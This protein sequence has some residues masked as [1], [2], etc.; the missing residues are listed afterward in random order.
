MPDSIVG[1]NFDYT[2]NGILSRD[3]MF[4]PTVNTP[5]IGD[6]MTIRQFA[7]YQER[8]PLVA[9]LT[10]Q[11]KAYANCGRSFTDGID[12]TNA[13]LSLTPLELNMEWC[14]DDFEQTLLIGNNLAEDFLRDGIEEFNP[15]GTQIQSIIDELVND[16]MR[17]DT[18]RIFSFGDTN[19]AD[20]DWNQLDGLWT[21]LIANSGVGSSYCVRRTGHMGTGTLA[22][23]Q[24][25]ANLK[26][27]YEESA[28]ILKQI[29]NNQKYFAVTGSVYENLLSSYESNTTGSERMFLNLVQGQGDQGT[30]LLYRG[31]PVYPIYAWDEALADPTNPLNGTTTNLILYTTR[32]NHVAGFK[33]QEDADR[34][35]GW[36]ER[37]DRKYYVEGFYRMGYTYLHCDLQS[38]S[39]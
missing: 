18:F 19:D 4:K 14:K 32:M 38:I 34:I 24:A 20:A 35:A 27:A 12:I 3:V 1:V 15:S 30:S 13:T 16:V 11:I 22:A 21:Q 5:A 9:S 7:R 6:L 31:I 2:Y 23:G 26:A 39:Y 10:K 29:P 17:R 33:R 28:I 25:L 37:K 8:I 36:Y